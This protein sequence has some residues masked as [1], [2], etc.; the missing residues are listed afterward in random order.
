VS[1][2]ET[3][4]AFPLDRILGVFL[5]RVFVGLTANDS[6]NFKD[7]R[8]ARILHGALDEIPH[9]LTLF[10]IDGLIDVSCTI[11]LPLGLC[12]DETVSQMYHP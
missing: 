9:L 7:A 12:V 8:A 1:Q 3:D 6:L 4:F 10:S 11:E 2:G 5:D